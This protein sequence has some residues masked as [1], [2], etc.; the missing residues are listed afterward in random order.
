MIQS[1][2][3]LFSCICFLSH[4]FLTSLLY[5]GVKFITHAPDADNISRRIRCYLKFLTKAAQQVMDCSLRNVNIF[6][7]PNLVSNH[8]KSQYPFPV[9]KQKMRAS[10]SLTVSAIS[11]PQTRT[12]LS[13]RQKYRSPSRISVNG[14]IEVTCNA[15]PL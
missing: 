15:E 8:F 12:V 14:N 3:A 1:R 2:F 11:C 13:S 9:D 6:L 7:A 4:F 10:N 5:S